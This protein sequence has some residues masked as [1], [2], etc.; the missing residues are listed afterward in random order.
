MSLETAIAR[1]QEGDLAQA[2]RLYR[3][4]LR[5]QPQNAD[6]LHL[7]G[8]VALQAGQPQSALELIGQSVRIQPQQPVAHLNLGVA[9]QQLNHL[10][11]ALGC[12]E[13][14]LQLA[15]DYPDAL[16]NRADAL[17]A[18]GRAEEALRSLARALQLQP[19]FPMALNNRGNALRALGRF[20]EALASYEQSLQLQP[21]SSRTLNNRG[22]VLRDLGRLEEALQSFEQ[23]LRLDPAYALA[24]YNRS[25][26]LLELKRYE[27]ALQGYER[28]LQLN[29]DDADALT[30]RGIALLHLDRAGQALESLDRAL[31][32]RPDFPLA[33]NNRG[34]ALGL[35]NRTEEAVACYERALRQLP[36]N[37]E[38]LVNCASALG[39]LQQ[40]DRAVQRYDRALQFWRDDA[41]LFR[42]RGDALLALGRAAEALESYQQAL[43]LQT[44]HPDALFSAG[45]CLIVLR[46]FEEARDHFQKVCALH[47]DYPYARGYH[48]HARLRICDWTDVERYCTELVAA[49]SRGA[50]ADVPFSLLPVSDSASTQ[51]QCARTFVADRYP[52]REAQQ[53][54]PS[55]AHERIRL[56]YVSGDLRNH[57]VGRLLAGVFESHDRRRFEVNAMALRPP[58]LDHPFGK[59]VYDAFDRFIDVSR[60]SDA[61][62]ARMM[63]DMEIDIAIDLAGFTEGQRTGI[64]ARRGAPVQV[65]YIGFPGTMGAPYIDYIIADEFVIPPAAAAHYAEKVVYLPDCFHPTD[66]RRPVPRKVSRAQFG[67]PESSL[68]LCSLNNSYKYTRRMLDVWARLLQQVPDGVL[69]LLADDPPAETNLRRHASECGIAPERLVF[70]RRVR[71]E[72]HLARL[73]C[74]DLFL[75]TLPFNAGATASDVLWAG[76]PLLTC[77][78]EAFASRMAGSLLRAAG[79]TELVTF[80]LEEYE[81]RAIELINAPAR[82]VELRRRLETARERSA[83]FDT[84][85]YCRNLEAAFEIMW[86]RSQCGESPSHITDSAAARSLQVRH[87]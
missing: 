75:D 12:F 67:L 4:V 8:V 28:L 29:P 39:E 64:F 70:S 25:N 71:Y 18:L 77:V 66:N 6:A 3:E 41:A 58:E 63:R 74:A 44:A 38:I 59:R 69:W 22:N 84:G 73:T 9:Q 49:V 35:L 36:D 85:R 51:L 19:D 68:V 34:N 50:A 42:K 79:L 16:N 24:L 83:L 20:D 48:L 78:G 10:E 80:S 86:R 37:P 1:H 81:R 26:A 55:Y 76:V 15:P 46:R 31:Q 60:R 65:N 62:I 40:Y 14:A 45:M 7:L 53:G 17:L 57:I 21:N 82:L 27:P 2:E 32:L 5:E 87:G 30:H 61:E 23:A 33:L 52:S 47:P 56:A 43:R 13:R 11:Q 72:D 54:T